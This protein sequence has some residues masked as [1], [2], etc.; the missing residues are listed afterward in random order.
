MKTGFPERARQTEMPTRRKR[1]QAPMKALVSWGLNQEWARGLGA[2]A[3]ESEAGEAR[4]KIRYN[5]V[6]L[7]IFKIFIYNYTREKRLKSRRDIL[8]RG[9]KKR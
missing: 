4:R 2:W 5:M 1:R 8:E 9:Q 6:R 3:Q 7:S